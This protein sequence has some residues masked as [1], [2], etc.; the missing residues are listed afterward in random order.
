MADGEGM[1]ITG[2][3]SLAPAAEATKVSDAVLE[4]PE[5]ATVVESDH[6]GLLAWPRHCDRP[7][8]LAY[9]G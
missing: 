6:A 5:C 3:Q 7:M 2:D 4:C 9:N 8:R 1:Q